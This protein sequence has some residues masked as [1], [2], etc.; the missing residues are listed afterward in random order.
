MQWFH[1]LFD[2]FELSPAFY[3]ELSPFKLQSADETFPLASS[4]DFHPFR[5][6][7]KLSQKLH[8]QLLQSIVRSF[9]VKS[10]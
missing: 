9:R 6:V 1:S 5:V 10:N 7:A 2:P 8:F 4:I 3:G